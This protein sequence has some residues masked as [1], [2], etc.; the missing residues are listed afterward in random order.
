MKPELKWCRDCNLPVFTSCCPLCGERSLSV[1]I[2][3]PYDPRPAFSNDIELLKKLLREKLGVRD[4]TKIL[5]EPVLLNRVYYLDSVDEVIV[6]G[7]RS[8]TVK[9]DCV[10]RDFIVKPWG[11]VAELIAEEK[12][13]YYAEL[14]E[15]YSKGSRLSRADIVEGDLPE[16]EAYV[17]F[18]AKE[19]FGILHLTGKEVV[20]E[21]VWTKEVLEFPEKRSILEVF[22]HLSGRVEYLK[23]K[24]VKLI[25][26]YCFKGGLKPIVNFSGGKD[27]TVVLSIVCEAGICE[28]VLSNT[29][30]EFAESLEY[31]RRVGAKIG[32]EVHEVVADWSF[33]EEVFKRHGPPARDNR[34]CTR[35]LKI[36]PLNKFLGEKYPLADIV[37][38]TGQRKY[39]SP[40]RARA[41]YF[42]KSSTPGKV[43]YIASPIL[44]WTT[45]DVYAYLYLNKIEVN[46]LYLRGLV[47]I[48]CFMCPTM[49]SVD[50][51]KIEEFYGKYYLW[52]L[53]ELKKYCRERNIDS[54]WVD[55]GLWRWLYKYPPHAWRTA[56]RVS[57]NLARVIERNTREIAVLRVSKK[58]ATI[59]FRSAPSSSFKS[60]L[61]MLKVKIKGSEFSYRKCSGILAGS[62][63][64]V[65]GSPRDLLKLLRKIVEAYGMAN[66]CILCRACAEV[67]LSKSISFKGRSLRV[68]LDKCL[69]CG[70]CVRICPVAG[71]LVK[72]AEALLRQAR[73]SVESG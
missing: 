22:E 26:R 23:E 51:K 40:K 12:L 32:A 2:S 29:G 7:E 47:R 31:S 55:Y 45:L 72:K 50:F 13:G 6:A 52:W 57:L 65:R 44:N 36:L 18:V 25:E 35:V 71:I 15:D 64:E 62:R 28:A 20:V 46:P 19:T 14:K 10:E 33:F 59:V 39:E 42:A 21:E 73:F 3:P 53:E 56:K 8:L 17:P 43:K 60:I 70:E 34:W 30:L 49:H 4:Y 37:S 27:S 54:K 16:E 5:V 41:G 68:D 69:G 63:V 48:G 38:I 66:Y 58:K 67:C 61:S 24:A 1:N 11:K 9:Y